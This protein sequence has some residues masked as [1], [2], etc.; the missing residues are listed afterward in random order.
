MKII[1]IE[2][3]KKMITKQI[4]EHAVNYRT[5]YVATDGKEFDDETTCRTYEKSLACALKTNLKEMS[6]RDTS[7]EEDLFYTGSCETEVFIVV[8]KTKEDILHIKQV[9]FGFGASEIQVNNWISE[10]DIDSV[11]L[12]TIGYNNEWVYITRLN[13]IVKNIVGEKYKLVPTIS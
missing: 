11:I 4:E 1:K 7:T 9:A 2:K 13:N 5:V 6:I 12:V 10:E 3:F 8:P